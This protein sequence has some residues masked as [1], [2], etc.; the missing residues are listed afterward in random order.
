MCALL[1]PQ[2]RPSSWSR[3]SSSWQQLLPSSQ[4]C[5]YPF[6]VC[7]ALQGAFSGAWTWHIRLRG[8]PDPA[9]ALHVWT[10]LRAFAQHACHAALQRACL[11]VTPA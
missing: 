10:P 4:S 11:E 6:C 9:A 5:R 2:T 7:R 3:R 8:K 1:R